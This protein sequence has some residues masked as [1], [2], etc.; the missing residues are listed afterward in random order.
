MKYNPYIKL[1]LQ[2]FSQFYLGYYRTYFL[3]WVIEMLLQKSLRDKGKKSYHQKINFNRRLR[4]M[5][6]FGP[7][8][9]LKEKLLSTLLAL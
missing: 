8:A 5:Y 7:E 6:V 9:E 2:D 3:F 1:F 4:F